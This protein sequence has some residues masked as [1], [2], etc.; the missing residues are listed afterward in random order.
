MMHL[1][2]GGH[3]ENYGLL[4]LL[5]LR[6]PKILVVNGSEIKSVDDYARDIIAAMEHAR[7]LFNCSFTS[8]TDGTDVL[9]EIKNKFVG[10][11]LRKYEF[12][13]HYSKNNSEDDN[14]V[15]EGHI[16]LIAPRSPEN[17]KKV[18]CLAAI[19]LWCCCGQSDKNGLV[20][21]QTWVDNNCEGKELDEKMWGPGPYLTEDDVKDIEGCPGGFGCCECCHKNCCDCCGSCF[22]FPRHPTANQFYTPRM[23]TAYHRE[24]YRACMECN[25]F[26]E[27]D[28]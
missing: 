19:K 16:V 14:G 5:K 15:S 28:N 21:N 4:P 7:K 25:H 3:F 6:L 17:P 23:F 13:V 10:K 9:T 1:S 26:L 22:K 24:G 18:K 12:K 20:E 2:D 27:N 8:M 11:H